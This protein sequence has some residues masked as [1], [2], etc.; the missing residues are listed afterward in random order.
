MEF[1]EFLEK[2]IDKAIAERF[3]DLEEKI[4]TSPSFL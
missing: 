1:E 2:R 3:A 4:K